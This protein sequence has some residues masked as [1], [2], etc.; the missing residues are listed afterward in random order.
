MRSST[1][2]V[3]G[4]RC[5]SHNISLASYAKSDALQTAGLLFSEYICL[6]ILSFPWYAPP[7]FHAC[8]LDAH[9]TAGH[10][11]CLGWRRESL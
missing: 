4:R 2:R 6:A 1:G 3:R 8:Y 5:V 9:V 10:S 11:Q 7:S